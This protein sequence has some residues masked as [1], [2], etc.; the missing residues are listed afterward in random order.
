MKALLAALL[1]A[2]CLLCPCAQGLMSREESGP[3]ITEPTDYWHF[4]HDKGLGN[5]LV[6]IAAGLLFWTVIGHN[7]L[8]LVLE[9]Y[10]S[11]KGDKES[12]EVEREAE[13]E[14]HYGHT[15]QMAWHRKVFSFRFSVTAAFIIEAIRFG[16][17]WPSLLLLCLAWGCRC[18]LAPERGWMKH[19]R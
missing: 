4:N 18:A 16:H 11:G 2:F 5:Q 14:E 7:S 1:L 3:D 13:V 9:L 12:C 15:S 19:R 8:K 10:E 17:G 6:Q